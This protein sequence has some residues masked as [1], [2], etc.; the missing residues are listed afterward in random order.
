MFAPNAD[1]TSPYDLAAAS[2][3][4]LYASHNER[5]VG[6][7]LSSLGALDEAVL[8]RLRSDSD[9]A[10]AFWLNLHQAFTARRQLVDVGRSSRPFGVAG[11]SIGLDDIQHGI[12]RGGKWKY[13]LGYV[14][15][16]FVR[17]FERRHELQEPDPR[18]HIALRRFEHDPDSA[19]AFTAANVDEELSEV[20]GEYLD[21]VVDYD[22]ERDVASVSRLF[23]WF[24]GDFGGVPGVRSLLHRHEVVPPTATPRL[25][26]LSKSTVDE[27]NPGVRRDAPED[28]Q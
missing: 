24:R 17:Q 2:G 25:D 9:A 7:L 4:L 10:L 18:A 3:R 19:E 13:G 26:F 1:T 22:S 14:P 8:D 5:P 15:N 16:P 20:T 11:T 27:A 23:F 6:D 12:L 28:P 21:A